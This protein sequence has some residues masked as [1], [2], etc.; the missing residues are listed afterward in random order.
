MGG[1][2]RCDD[3]LHRVYCVVEGRADSDGLELRLVSDE[4]EPLRVPLRDLVEE[5][6][7]DHRRLVNDDS[8]AVKVPLSE[9]LAHPSEHRV[10]R[11]RAVPSRLAETGG[12]LSGERAEL[13]GASDGFEGPREGA[14][15]CRLAG[16]RASVDDCKPHEGYCVLD[17]FD[18]A[19]VRREAVRP[20]EIRD[21]G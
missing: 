3:A 4:D 16:A 12:G 8:H 21:V 13:D 19:L 14:D 17:R 10:D 2:E 11:G 9:R 7:R 5:R 18:L 15:D 1:V 20:F 6:R